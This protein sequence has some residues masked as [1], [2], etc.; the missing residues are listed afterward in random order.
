MVSRSSWSSILDLKYRV[1]IEI[2]CRRAGFSPVLDTGRKGVLRDQ[3]VLERSAAVGGQKGSLRAQ[4]PRLQPNRGRPPESRN[5]SSGAV[6]RI[7]AAK[8]ERRSQTLLG[9]R[10]ISVRRAAR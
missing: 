4:L 6:L 2:C 1:S 5:A 9:I 3:L 8:Q 7:R 10:R